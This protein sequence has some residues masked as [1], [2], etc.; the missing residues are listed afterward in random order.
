MKNKIENIKR[1][2]GILTAHREKT[3][4]INIVGK[5]CKWLF[6]TMDDEDNQQINKHLKNIEE[7][8]L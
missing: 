4:L 2:A 8:N 1:K 3:G 7:N 5:T 6:G